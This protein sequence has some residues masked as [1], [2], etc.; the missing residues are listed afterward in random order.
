MPSSGLRSVSTAEPEADLLRDCDRG[1]STERIGAVTGILVGIEA[2]RSFMA[3]G[4]FVAVTVSLRMTLDL[5]QQ[6]GQLGQQLK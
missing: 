1:R 6:P 3:D 5:G 4:S 2:R